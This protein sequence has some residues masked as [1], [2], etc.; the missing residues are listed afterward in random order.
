MH[1][2]CDSLTSRHNNP[3]WFDMPLKKSIQYS[4]HNAITEQL[5]IIADIKNRFPT[6]IDGYINKRV[7]YLRW[8]YHL[9]CV[10]GVHIPQRHHATH[11]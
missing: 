2:E 8:I 3:R 10:V 11:K 7:E 4:P 6:M 1:N 5:S 9:W